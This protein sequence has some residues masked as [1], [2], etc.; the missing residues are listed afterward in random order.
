MYSIKTVRFFC[1][2]A[3]AVVL[4]G[5]SGFAD[6]VIL[7]VTPDRAWSTYAVARQVPLERGVQQM[8]V[9]VSGS[10]SAYILDQVVIDKS[11]P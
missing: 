6:F 10:N 5:Q 4:M 8:K 7:P 2:F 1:G 11:K 9:S 3:A